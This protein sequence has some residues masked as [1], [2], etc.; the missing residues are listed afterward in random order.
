MS[1]LKRVVVVIVLVLMSFL[2]LGSG[3]SLSRGTDARSGQHMV[4]VA[5][6]VY[7]I[8]ATGACKPGAAV[9]G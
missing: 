3:G 6:D 5:P 1:L 4:A 7:A 8:M 9:G 2:L